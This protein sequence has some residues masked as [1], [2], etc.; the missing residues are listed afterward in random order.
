M[1]GMLVD[2][3]VLRKVGRMRLEYVDLSLISESSSS[4]IMSTCM[5]LFRSNLHEDVQG[6]GSRN[7][8]FGFRGTGTSQSKA[9]GHI[10]EDVDIV[11]HP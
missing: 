6:L 4:S 3:V 5:Y 10:E 1:M 7:R 11:I 2:S 8:V 9:L